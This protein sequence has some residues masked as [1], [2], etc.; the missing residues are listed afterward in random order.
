MIELGAEIAPHR[1][2]TNLVPCSEDQRD[3][4]D[5]AEYGRWLYPQ[6]RNQREADEQFADADEVR[7]EN[8]MRLHHVDQKPAIEADGIVVDEAR[9]PLLLK[10]AV[11][12]G[13]AGN[14]VFSEKNKNC[15]GQNPCDGDGASSRGV[16]ASW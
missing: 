11:C 10:S 4:V 12:E 2:G 15:A 8:R 14:F 9:E 5:D 3:H 16:S 13:R 1:P 6:A 7:E